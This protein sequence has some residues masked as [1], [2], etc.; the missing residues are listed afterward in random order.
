MRSR[1]DLHTY[2][3]R[4]IAFGLRTPFCQLLL[5]MGLGKS[6]STFVII[7][8]LLNWC[9][10][11]KP[12]IV[13]PRLVAE[14]TWSDEIEEWDFLSHLR[15]SKVVGS[16]SKRKKALTAEADI[17]VIGRDNLPWLVDLCGSFW[18]FDMVVLDEST[19]FKSHASLRFRKM[20]E[21]LKHG[22]I[23]R[24]IQL[25]G[26]PAPNGLLDLWAPLYLLDKG[27]RLGASMEGYRNRY[28]VKNEYKHRYE[29]RP[30]GAESIQDKIK[31]ICISMRKE[32]WLDLKPVENVTRKID[33]PNM[34]EYIKFREEAVLALE[35]GEITA[36]NAGALYTKLL[37]FCNGAV[38]DAD[39][40]FHVVHDAKLDLLEE[41][42]DTLNGAPVIVFYCFQSDIAR[43]SQRIK[44]VQT[45]TGAK[46]P[47]E[48]INAWNKGEIE[49]LLAHPASAGH[50]LNLQHGGHR[51]IWFGVPSS[52]ELYQQAVARL[53]R[54]GQ[55]ESVVNMHLITAKTIEET[56][57][58][59]LI[60]KTLTQDTLIDALR[61]FTE[62]AAA[63][64]ASRAVAVVED[65]WI[66]S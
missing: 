35:E 31:D 55:P 33:L 56:V 46:N 17:W 7:D 49:V 66:N 15:I 13:A 27:E 11:S 34:E 24:M 28:F 22:K 39:K 12:L 4:A 1:E 60:D 19:S 43:I 57:V 8:T 62:D 45:L 10:I 25:T 44:K 29:I 53:D 36:V 51:I 52:L 48:I 47:T 61:A 9:E 50:G 3:E 26:T 65:D 2:Q 63:Y 58:A 64:R 32:D 5:E 42:I 59:R 37:Q 54:Q 14:K 20:K 38:Y 23:Q 18:P 21:V 41:I 16:A 40:N 6:V 30:G